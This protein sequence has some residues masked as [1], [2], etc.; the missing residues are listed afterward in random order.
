MLLGLR[1]L[2]S[3]TAATACNSSYFYQVSTMSKR[4][5]YDFFQADHSGP[6]SRPRAS[7]RASSRQASQPSSS[8]PT[9]LI[10]APQTGPLGP[11]FSREVPQSRSPIPASSRQTPRTGFSG[12]AFERQPFQFSTTSPTSIPPASQP[13]FSTP[14]S[15][16][17]ASRTS[18]LN[19]TSSG[20]PEVF[21][22]SFSNPT[23][24]EQASQERYTDPAPQASSAYPEF[25][26]SAYHT[27]VPPLNQVLQIPLLLHQPI[28]LLHPLPKGSFRP[29]H[30][31][32]NSHSK[33][34]TPLDIRTA[35]VFDW[36]T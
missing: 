2:A 6:A 24:F 20:Q 3:S 17:Q 11:A 9:S 26:T 33:L 16:A 29:Q 7:V 4:F 25:I 34:S 27:T 32:H 35:G 19:P 5:Y 14:A 12:P 13:S 21:D 8:N 18:P 23:G 10:Q 31:P 36:K 22:M 28:T 1:H 15:T 30:P